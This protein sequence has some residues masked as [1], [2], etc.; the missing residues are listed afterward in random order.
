[1]RGKGI[2]KLIGRRLTL[3]NAMLIHKGRMHDLLDE[4]VKGARLGPWVEEV[5]AELVAGPK[6]LRVIMTE[7]RGRRVHGA[8]HAGDE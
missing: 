6:L 7:K 3:R 1:M 2:K 4:L 5:S 8:R